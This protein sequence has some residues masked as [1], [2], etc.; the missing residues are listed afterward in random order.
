V[1]VCHSEHDIIQQLNGLMTAFYVAIVTERV[2][3]IHDDHEDT[4]TPSLFPYLQQGLIRWNIQ[5]HPEPSIERALDDASSFDEF[6]QEMKSLEEVQ[7]IELYAT[8]WLGEQIW[9]EEHSFLYKNDSSDSDDD[10]H[11]LYRWA[12]WTIFHFSEGTLQLAVHMRQDAGL[13]ISDEPHSKNGWPNK[14]ANF[15]F[16]PY[17]A[18]REPSGMGSMTDSEILECAHNLYQASVPMAYRVRGTISDLKFDRSLYLA[19]ASRTHIKHTANHGI[20]TARGFDVRD[21][22]EYHFSSNYAPSEIANLRKGYSW[23]HKFWAELVIMIESECLI[24][25]HPYMVAA[26]KDPILAQSHIMVPKSLADVAEKVSISD[27]DT[28]KRCVVRVGKSANCHDYELLGEI[29]QTLPWT[30]GL[31]RIAKYL[32]MM[33]NDDDHHDHPPATTTAWNKLTAD[34]TTYR[35]PTATKRRKHRH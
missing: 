5:V 29:V 26:E 18:A 2:L 34:R 27:K 33:Q 21:L 15:L 20:H 3:I 28:M 10:Q 13:A 22:D 1:N 31:N 11:Q 32:R 19:S 35:M 9:D 24:Q 30:K 23:H 17:Y 25:I 14:E 7:G 8:S 6:E 4:K 16:K 12:F